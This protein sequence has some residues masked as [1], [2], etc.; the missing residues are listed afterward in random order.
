MELAVNDKGYYGFGSFRLDPARR[1]LTRNGVPIK[2][3]AKQFDALLYF[4]QNPNRVIEKDELFAAIWPG[5]IV[6]ESSLTQAIFQLRRVLQSDE[7][8]R[9]I[10]TAPGRGY[11]WVAEIGWQSAVA[12]DVTS[13]DESPGQFAPTATSVG[14]AVAPAPKSKWFDGRYRYFAG[15]AVHPGGATPARAAEPTRL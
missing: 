14:P 4:L 8:D 15:C 7:T 11:R 12:R 2:L 3:P 9:Y 13:S 5:R 6:E 1:R 10:V